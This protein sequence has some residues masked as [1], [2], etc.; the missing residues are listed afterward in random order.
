MRFVVYRTSGGNNG[1]QPCEGAFKETI[2]CVDER[3]YG[4]P[5]EFNKNQT[6][7]QGDWFSFGENHRI[8][9]R[10]HI[11]RDVGKI[12]VWMIEFNTVEELVSFCRSADVSGEVVVGKYHKNSDYNFIE[13]YDDYRE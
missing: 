12:E 9:E 7:C 2:A 5:E 6:W 10:G 3:N 1:H 4:S 13:I 11:L 8:N